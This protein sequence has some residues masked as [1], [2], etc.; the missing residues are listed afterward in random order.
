[1]EPTTPQFEPSALPPPPRRTVEEE[2]CASLPRQDPVAAQA[3][4]C[5][6]VARL[7]AA[8]GPAERQLAALFTFDQHAQPLG[9]R[10][11]ALYGSGDAQLRSHDRQ[12]FIA[13]Q[14]LAR[15]FTA[16]YA[17]VQARIAGAGGALSH[18]DA[19]TVAVQLL[20]HRQAE[21]MLRLFRYKKRNSE[22]WEQIHATY[23]S[24]RAHGLASAPR[25]QRSTEGASPVERAV[26][27]GYIQILLLGTM[28][29]GQFS[30]RELLWARNWIARWCTLLALRAADADGQ[31]PEARSGF[32]VD[33]GSAEGPR[34]PVPGETGAI[35]HLDTAPLL[36]AIDEVLVATNS[37]PSPAS[38]P[39]TAERHAQAVLL[40]RLRTLFAPVV[41][42]VR[43]RGE[44]TPAAASVLAVAGL[45]QIVQLLRGE[46]QRGRRPD[47][48]SAT[49][50]DEIT[51]AAA[52][53]HTRTANSVMGAGGLD[54][55]SIATTSGPPPR[56]W[57]VK[58]Q[59]DSGCRM[60]GQ[61][62]DLN[63][64]IPGSLIAFRASD[65]EPW[66]LGVIRRL[67]R[68]MVDHV[69]LGVE[70]VGRSPRYV[71]IVTGDHLG[72]LSGD[73]PDGNQKCM[74]ALYVPASEQHPTMPIRTLLVPAVAFHAGATLTLISSKATYA[75]LLNKPLEQQTGFVW[76]SFAVIDK[77]VART[78]PV[79]VG[80]AMPRPHGNPNAAGLSGI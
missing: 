4:L 39:A 11:L 60:R 74:G 17:H 61:T 22:V 52:D 78:R 9:R 56:R 14:R 36:A 73:T 28:G 35:L 69:E 70:Y 64:L 46:A 34:R 68:L 24:A 72:A 45:A 54:A 42:H 44:R 79:A 37:A 31:V 65:L 58:D 26:E 8:R 2:L 48:A 15:T 51:I 1:M 57:Q 16:A 21:L 41:V 80:T 18:E 50:F 67:R 30:P 27:Q 59:S 77:V 40:A 75:L 71:K 49:Q 12:F 33:P 32:V 19:G 20:R 62:T 13:A 23:Q 55:Y 53:G 7:V 63:G 47:A 38:H 29:T 76:A 43:R 3:L 5:E 25:T 10:L 66:T 6:A